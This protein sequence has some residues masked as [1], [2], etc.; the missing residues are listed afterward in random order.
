MIKMIKKRFHKLKKKKKKFN[1][2]TQINEIIKGKMK[3][4][5]LPIH[6]LKIMIMFNNQII[7]M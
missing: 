2:L 6:K 4:Q 5:L 3:K 1:K 7:S